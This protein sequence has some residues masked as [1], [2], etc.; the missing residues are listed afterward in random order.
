MK[1][2]FNRASLQRQRVIAKQA[3]RIDANHFFNLL[4]SPELLEVVESQ[5]P[6][7]RERQY[8]PTV[9]LSMFL[10]QVM[11]S[12]GSCQQAVNEAIVHSML[13]G[14]KTHSAKTGGYCNARLRLPQSMV[15]EIAR[16]IGA[17]LGEQLPK[18]WL[19]RDRHVK[20]IDGTSTS[21]P[22]TPENQAL[23]PQPGGQAVGVGFPK[24]RI[25]GIVSLSHG[26]VLQ[27]AM[28]PCKGKGTGE[29]GLLRPLINTFSP[30]DVVLADGYYCSYFLLAELQAR[31]VDAVMERHGAR[32]TDF[33]CG[34]SLGRRD[35][36]ITWNKP[37]RPDWM[38]ETEYETH[39]TTLT[40]REAKVGNKILVTTLL[41]Q[42]LTSKH[43]LK[44]LYHWRWTIELD[45]RNIKT[46][47]GMETLSC[48][49]P[50]MCEKEMWVYLLAYNLIRL[51]MAQAA[52]QDRVLPRQLSFKHTLQVWLAWSVRQR[53]FPDTDT[54]HELFSLIAQIRVGDRPNRVEPRAVKRRPK[55]Y[56]RL[57]VPREQARRA[58]IRK[59][60]GNAA[61]A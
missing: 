56:A 25:V 55:E 9:T 20:L 26:A 50:A 5:L 39:P 54:T 11:S 51:L 18:A 21:L 27:A 58:I 15:E 19:W 41:S 36:L 61:A 17:S 33:R 14:M 49:T 42:K 32:H 44:A 31:G 59:K 46:T 6:E 53:Y 57:M 28:G 35:H 16:H 13:N 45:I 43:D 23:Y 40:V 4:T 52:H 12:D 7:H 60:R 38:S 37:E 1:Q 30:G 34:K 48:M 47:L 3:E 29:H 10:G 8:P 2:D 24:A 22:D